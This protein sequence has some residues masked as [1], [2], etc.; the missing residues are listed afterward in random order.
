MIKP[1]LSKHQRLLALEYPEKRHSYDSRDTIFHALG[2]GIGL[3][4]LDPRQLRFV[5]EPHLAALPTMAVALAYPGFWYRNLD[6]GLDFLRTVHA[7]ERIA[8]HRPLPVAT[9]VV[10]RPR[11]IEVVDKGAG[12]G[13]LVVANA[14]S[15]TS[16]AECCSR[17]CGRPLSAVATAGSIPSPQSRTSRNRRPSAPDFA[18]NLPTSP[19]AA[20]V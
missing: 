11:V 2:V 9:T 6:T 18:M 19:Q 17:P 13:A 12:K 16:I 7:S 3:D 1:G 4:P 8:I 14:T 20:L 5:Y 15:A 10:A